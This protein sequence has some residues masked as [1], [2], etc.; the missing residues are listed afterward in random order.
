MT[1]N[2]YASPGET[3]PKARDAGSKAGGNPLSAV[4]GGLA[5]V[6]LALIVVALTVFGRAEYPIPIVLLSTGA[7]CALLSGI[8][9]AHTRGKRGL[10]VAFLG[11]VGFASGG[12]A[13]LLLGDASGPTGDGNLGMA[14]FLVI[15]GFW[16]GAILF[17]G[18]GVWWGIRFHRRF[19]PLLDTPLLKKQPELRR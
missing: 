17:G 12:A 18:L 2:P 14:I 6:G 8:P 11:L 4:F 3:E 10:K 16:V 1:S 19:A 15:A 13:G 7:V 5:I 9:W